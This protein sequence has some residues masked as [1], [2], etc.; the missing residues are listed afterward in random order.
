MPEAA[1]LWLE[2]Q[3]KCF[4]EKCKADHLACQLHPAVQETLA[5]IYTQPS[6]NR[7]HFISIKDS[8]SSEHHE[9]EEQLLFEKRQDLREKKKKKSPLVV[10]SGKLS[11]LSIQG[12]KEVQSAW[13]KQRKRWSTRRRHGRGEKSWNSTSTPLRLTYEVEGKIF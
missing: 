1:V 2:P 11:C 5:C 8:R 9:P 3:P 4:S 7:T 10:L 12:E 13:L 6:W